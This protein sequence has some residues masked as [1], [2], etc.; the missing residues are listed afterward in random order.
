MSQVTITI[1]EKLE[2]ELRK[3]KMFYQCQGPQG[4]VKLTDEELVKIIIEQSYN[5][6]KLDPI[7][8][9]LFW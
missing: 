4:I 1:D 9:R 5:A 8:K 7:G 2:E 6:L 3:L